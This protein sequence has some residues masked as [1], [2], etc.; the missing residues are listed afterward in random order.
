M[1][2]P[3]NLKLIYYYFPNQKLLR[4][5]LMVKKLGGVGPVDNRPSYARDGKLYQGANN[6]G[7]KKSYL[8]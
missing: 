4:I 7:V 8:R 1:V 3:I 2:K 6:V 5:A